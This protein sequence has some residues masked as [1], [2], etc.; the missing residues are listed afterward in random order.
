MTAIIHWT[1]RVQDYNAQNDCKITVHRMT[2]DNNAQ[3]DCK[4]TVHRATT[5]GNAGL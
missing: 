5:V 2:E 3:N 1:E 4:I